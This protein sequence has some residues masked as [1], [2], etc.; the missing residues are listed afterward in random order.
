[1][2]RMFLR[3]KTREEIEQQCR[4]QSV[5]CTNRNMAPGDEVIVV[6]T[7][8]RG[9]VMYSVFSGVY[10]G[11]KPDGGAFYSHQ[12]WYEDEPWFAAIQDFFWVPA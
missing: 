11:V 4:D 9:Y 7:P 10:S 12:T 6:G 3:H 2:P 5:P 8:P 1:M